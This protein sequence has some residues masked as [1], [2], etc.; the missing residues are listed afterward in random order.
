MNK[1][2][3]V[4]HVNSELFLQLAESL[5]TVYSN[6]S[7][8]QC[9]S[10]PGVE[11]GKEWLREWGTLGCYQALRIVYNLTSRPSFSVRAQLRG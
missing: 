8:F 4:L 3:L 5:S 7:I 10:A 9:I 1:T 2:D 6:N 11:G